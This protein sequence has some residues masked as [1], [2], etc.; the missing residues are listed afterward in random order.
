MKYGLLAHLSCPACGDTDL[1]LE[2]QRTSRLRCFHSSLPEDTPGWNP[3]TS[4]LTEVEE[5]ALHCGGCGRGYRI[6]DGIPRLVLEDQDRVASAHT[7][8]LF[9]PS[10]P[11][12]EEAFLD[13]AG[14]LTPADFTGRLALDVGCGF[15][16]GAFFAARYGAE[17]VAMDI[18]PEVVATARH[19]TRDNPRIH[20]VQADLMAMPFPS[21]VFDLVYAF[22][23]LHHLA[24]PIRGFK[25]CS[26]RVKV[27]GRLAVWLYGPR[28]GTSA[29]VSA[30]LRGLTRD[31]PTEDLLNV[32]RLIATLL[33]A[34]SHTPYRFLRHVP[35][36]SP[37]VSHLP[38][39]DH[40]KWPYDVVVADI[41]DR[42]RIPVTRTF[43][44]EEIDAMFSDG[45]YLDVK[46]LRRI[47]NN[48]S[49]RAVGIRR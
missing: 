16:R 8:T 7:D 12:W 18:D 32:S 2:T 48:E 46:V 43:R 1:R 30:L 22:G 25:L 49:F 3:G 35:G 15:G 27:G 34:G 24:D 40:H 41:Y 29:A 45:G 39:H 5:G 37:I 47:R 21:E 4:E 13:F 26:E 38:L 14:A 33:R 28:Q 9:D 19:N 23:V 10:R 42:L 36:L 11:E 6:S 31:M 17:V 44:H 20:V